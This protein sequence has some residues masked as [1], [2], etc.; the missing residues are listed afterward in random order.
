MIIT[1]TMVCWFVLRPCLTESIYL[2]T[3]AYNLV[4][5]SFIFSQTLRSCQRD[6]GNADDRSQIEVHTDERTQVHH[7]AQYSLPAIHPAS[8]N[9]SL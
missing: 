7:S 5:V 8:I 1:D 6:N 9:R 2:P 3:P 4:I